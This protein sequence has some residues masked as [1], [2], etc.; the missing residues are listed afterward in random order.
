M[1]NFVYIAI[2]LFTLTLSACSDKEP[3]TENTERELPIHEDVDINQYAKVF[4]DDDNCTLRIELDGESF[5]EMY[6]CVSVQREYG[7][8]FHEYFFYNAQDDIMYKVTYSREIFTW[9]LQNHIV[10]E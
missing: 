5:D 4:F 1:R 10:E 7:E 3:I 9:Q 6:Y 8:E 2:V